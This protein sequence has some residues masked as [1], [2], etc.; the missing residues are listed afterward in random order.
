MV[1][2]AGPQKPLDAHEIDALNDYLKRGGRVIAM[3]RRG[4]AR[5]SIDENALVAMVG[6]WGVKVGD[7]I[8]VDQVMRLF[9]GPAL[10]LDPIVQDY[11]VHPI[12]KDFKQRTISR[13]RAR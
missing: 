12:T 4:K 13:W 3:F 6:Q 1:A 9:A 10:G 7:D 5:R 2:I 8:V 11:G